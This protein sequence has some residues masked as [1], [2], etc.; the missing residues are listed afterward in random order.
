MFISAVQRA[1]ELRADDLDSG[2][3]SRGVKRIV[4]TRPGTMSFL[5]RM[6]GTQNEW[7]TSA[8]V[9]FSVT[10]TPSGRCISSVISPLICG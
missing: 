2:P 7:M 4:V 6:A 3:A 9:R 10:G 5:R 8:D 1:A